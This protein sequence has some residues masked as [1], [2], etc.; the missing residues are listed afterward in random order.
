MH[1]NPDALIAPSLDESMH[2]VVGAVISTPP[3]LLEQ[4]LRRPAFPLRQLGFLLQELRQYF[5]P[6]AKLRGGLNPALVLELGLV[7]PHD[8][9]T[10]TV[11]RDTT[12]SAQ[13][14]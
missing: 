13:S 5:D 14:P 7:A 3:Q 10:V 6:F 11:A 8:L 9:R 12:A 4:P 2:A 1:W